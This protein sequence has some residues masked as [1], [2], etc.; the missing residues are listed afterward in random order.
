[1]G[2]A[3]GIGLDHLEFMNSELRHIKRFDS[4]F[5]ISRCGYTGEDGFEV[6]VPEKAVLPFIESLTAVKD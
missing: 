4:E 1:M 6:S 3:L 5:R 2:D